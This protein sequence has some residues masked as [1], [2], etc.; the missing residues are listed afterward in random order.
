VTNLISVVVVT[1][2]RPDALDAVLRALSAQGDG[3]FE[4][5]VADDGSKPDTA[6]V[7]AAW[8]GRLGHRVLHVWQPDRG[9]RAAEIRNRAILA[10]NGD[11][12]IFLDGDCLARPNF[13]AA[14][15][16]LAQPR[17]FVTGNRALLSP[18]LSD[19]V[20]REG[21]PVERWSTAQW[22]HQRSRGGINRLAALL[23]LPLGPLRSWNAT[24][25]R[26]ARSCNLGVWRSDLIAVNGFDAGYA[27]WG[28][29]D[30][31]LFVRLIRSGVRRKDGRMATGVLHLWH[32]EADRASLPENDRRLAE[33]LADTRIAAKQGLLALRDEP[34]IAAP[35]S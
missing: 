19:R 3:G 8:N 22:Q 28:R 18:E 27:G 24:A 20:L 9:F 16:K 17:R 33:V 11:Y 12:C 2:N 32:P 21:L 30:S 35:V 7:A 5:V 4:V 23:Q 10:A 6:A 25:W 31:D 29:E 15:R 34:K 26:G 1:Y 14:H 13:I